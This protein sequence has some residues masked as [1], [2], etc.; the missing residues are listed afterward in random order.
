MSNEQMLLA[1]GRLEGWS[2]SVLASALAGLVTHTRRQGFHPQAPATDID[3]VMWI[4]FQVS[5]LRC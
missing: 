1:G 3:G 5:L 4:V 2:E